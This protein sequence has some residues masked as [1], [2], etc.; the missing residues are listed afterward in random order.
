MQVR[1]VARGCETVLGDAASDV[2]LFLTDEFLTRQ[3][4][5][6]ITPVN[7]QSAQ[8]WPFLAKLTGLW[9]LVIAVTDEHRSLKPCRLALHA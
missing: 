9:L 1:L 5:A 6:C 2:E 7:H 8:T 3:A 4:S